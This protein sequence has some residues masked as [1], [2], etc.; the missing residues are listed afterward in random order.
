MNATTPVL[1]SGR[2]I[3]ILTGET[4][5]AADN[6]ARVAAKATPRAYF[7]L[8]ERPADF[9][10][11]FV[12]ARRQFVEAA[13]TYRALK[14]PPADFNRMDLLASP[15][16]HP[17][18]QD[19]PTYRTL[20]EPP[21]DFTEIMAVPETM[22]IPEIVATPQELEALTRQGAEQTAPRGKAPIEQ[23]AGFTRRK[24][25]FTPAQHQPVA[26]RRTP[27]RPID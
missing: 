11:I 17:T 10:D 7:A 24:A 25:L 3:P 23:A 4:P 18:E 15:R 14:Q 9:K 21:V 13:A 22:L 16:R 19:V 5:T 2:A 20:T 26:A 8:T 1:E 12:P 27:Q 6:D